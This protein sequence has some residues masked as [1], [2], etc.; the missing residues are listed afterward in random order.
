VSFEVKAELGEERE[1]GR[2]DLQPFNARLPSLSV[3]QDAISNPERLRFCQNVNKVFIPA[4]MCHA[5]ISV[6]NII[7]KKMQK[8]VVFFFKM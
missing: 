2:D 4:R 7:I 8:S 3:C 1:R 5:T 6:Y